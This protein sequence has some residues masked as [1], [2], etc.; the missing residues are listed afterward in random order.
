MNI[1]SAYATAFYK[2]ST[3]YSLA[4]EG[5]VYTDL[6]VEVVVFEVLRFELWGGLVYSRTRVGNEDGA[7]TVCFLKVL[8]CLWSLT[9]KPSNSSEVEG[10]IFE[11]I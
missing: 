2:E 4:D 10:L 9:M 8:H 7:L 5:N 3:S 1:R 6:D 11:A